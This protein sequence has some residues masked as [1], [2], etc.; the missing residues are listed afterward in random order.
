[1]RDSLDVGNEHDGAYA[2]LAPCSSRLDLMAAEIVC[3]PHRYDFSYPNSF[4]RLVQLDT[5]HL[6]RPTLGL[7]IRRSLVRS[8]VEEPQ[9]SVRFVALSPAIAVGLFAFWGS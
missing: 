9:N 7:L 4:R 2:T 5:V 6:D 3:R 8:Q 1:M